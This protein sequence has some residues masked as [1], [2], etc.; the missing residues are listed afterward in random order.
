MNPAQLARLNNPHT[1]MRPEGLKKLEAILATNGLNT[2]AVLGAIRQAARTALATSIHEIFTIA[3]ALLLLATVLTFFLREVP[4]RK[5]NRFEPA[6][7]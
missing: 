6:A 7:E 1:Y 4:L 3:A 5:S 2:E